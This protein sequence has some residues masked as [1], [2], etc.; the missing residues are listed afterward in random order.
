MKKQKQKSKLGTGIMI[1]PCVGNEVTSELMQDIANYIGMR[2]LSEDNDFDNCP[3]IT[4]KDNVQ[5]SKQDQEHIKRLCIDRDCVAFYV[6]YSNDTLDSN[7][8]KTRLPKCI[9]S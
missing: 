7:I 1:V 3:C 5:L 8:E 6:V 9:I 4:F 2:N